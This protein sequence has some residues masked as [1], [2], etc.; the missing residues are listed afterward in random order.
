MR[1]TFCF[2][3]FRV[4]KYIGLGYIVAI[5]I[6]TRY[7]RVSFTFG[8]DR[9]L[10][11]PLM[12]LPDGPNRV[13]VRLQWAAR[14][15]PFVEACAKRYGDTFT[16]RF[17]GEFSTPYILCSNPQ[18]IGE[19]F[20][21]PPDVFA[22][23]CQNGFLQPL[24][25]FNSMILLDGDRHMQQRRLLTPPFHGERMREW[26]QLIC[27]ITDEAIHNWKIGQSFNLRSSMQ[28]ITLRVILQVVFGKD[29]EQR[30]EQIRQLLV[31]LLELNSFPLIS[32]L[33]LIELM[34]RYFGLKSPIESF[35][36]Q[37]QQLDEIL[38]AEIRYRRYIAQRQRWPKPESEGEDILSLMLSARDEAGQ[39]MTKA[40]LRDELMTLLVAG[41]ETTASAVSWALYWI[42]RFP[43]VKDRLLKEL[44]TLAADKDPNEIARLPY[45]SAVVSETLRI[46][47]ITLT[48]FERLVRAP[49]EIMG[50]KFEPGTVL[51]PCIYLTHHREDIYPEPK[52]FRPERFLE[53]QFSPY[54]YLPFGGGDRRCIG[55]AF[56]RFEMKLI[57]ATILLHFQLA[58]THSRPVKPVRR[59]V[60]LAPPKG[61]RMV[62]KRQR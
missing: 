4:G 16:L 40:E 7:K 44:N 39:P 59:G 37:K 15:I 5:Y 58:L 6:A 17:G 41:H 32:S 13:L 52:R 8:N 10:L 51:L 53:R 23:G 21:A 62:V 50:Y 36:Q 42:H 30:F 27:N 24:L 61:M 47:P 34:Q 28:Q 31:S 1:V 25:G 54:E 46:Y 11:V 38:V 49:V 19:I 22:S 3:V 45:L 57:L 55:M 14:P 18:A 33:P 56:A 2:H 29:S 20:T 43:E 9:K 35:L 60:T 26:G 48:T 12:K